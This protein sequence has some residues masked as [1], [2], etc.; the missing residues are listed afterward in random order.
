M[1]VHRG[2]RHLAAGRKNDRFDDTAL[3]HAVLT[4]RQEAVGHVVKINPNLQVCSGNFLCA[5][6][7]QVQRDDW[8][9][10]KK[11]AEA[12]PQRHSRHPAQRVSQ[13]SVTGGFPVAA[14]LIHRR[15]ELIHNFFLNAVLLRIG[16]VGS[17]MDKLRA[18]L[19]HLQRLR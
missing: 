16:S 15:T 14:A 13:S 10:L 18:W 6:A 9:L 4:E 3:Q 5:A 12:N 2:T 7:S 17:V 1:P 8:L 11:A 19:E